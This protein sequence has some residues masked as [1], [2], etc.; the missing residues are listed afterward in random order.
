M[1]AVR[2]QRPHERPHGAVAHLWVPVCGRLP[3][4]RKQLLPQLADG[5][6]LLDFA[7]KL[8]LGVLFVAIVVKV[9]LEIRVELTVDGSRR[10][11][12]GRVGRGGTR[13]GR[14][15]VDTGLPACRQRHRRARTGLATAHPA[16]RM[17]RLDVHPAGADLPTCRPPPHWRP[18]DG[19]RV[20][21]RVGRSKKLPHRR[22]RR[23]DIRSP[24]R[25]GGEH[26]RPQAEGAE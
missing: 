6:G 13:D 7:V 26:V 25:V 15:A 21:E 14:R 3:Q 16:T 8:L 19:H 12:V 20:G 11:V 17:R 4:I 10:L 2:E 18:L 22:Q 5:G 1:R 9:R 24:V 23:D